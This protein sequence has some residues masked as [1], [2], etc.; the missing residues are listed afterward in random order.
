MSTHMSTHMSARLYDHTSLCACACVSNQTSLHMCVHMCTLSAH[1]PVHVSVH[2]STYPPIFCSFAGPFGPESVLKKMPSESTDEKMAGLGASQLLDFSTAR[3]TADSIGSRLLDRRRG[4]AIEA[5]A[6]NYYRPLLGG[7]VVC[8]A[9]R[10]SVQLIRSLTLSTAAYWVSAGYFIAVGLVLLSTIRIAPM[11]ELVRRPTAWVFMGTTL[12]ANVQVAWMVSADDYCSNETCFLGADGRHRGIFYAV[13][14]LALTIWSGLYVMID[15]LPKRLFLP[16]GRYCLVFDALLTIWNYTTTL[17]IPEAV[18]RGNTWVWSV[19]DSSGNR[20]EVLSSV[21]IGNNA[22]MIHAALVLQFAFSAW[23]RPEKCILIKERLSISS[24]HLKR[25]CDEAVTVSDKLFGCDQG[26]SILNWTCKWH[27]LLVSV[28]IVLT[29]LDWLVDWVLPRN[30]TAHAL[31]SLSMSLSCTLLMFTG[32]LCNRVSV[33]KKLCRRLTCVYYVI[34]CTAAW[35]TLLVW[36]G[37]KEQWLWWMKTII[38]ALLSGSV[39][40]IDALPVEVHEVYS[41]S[42]LLMV[43]LVAGGTYAWLKVHTAE[44]Y[45][46]FDPPEWKNMAGYITFST[47]RKCCDFLFFQAHTHTHVHMHVHVYMHMSAHKDMHICRC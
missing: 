43:I 14:T 17:R 20:H 27:R 47:Y 45:S 8:Y 40:F 18:F 30:K 1:M 41:R 36:R 19:V 12:V 26:A 5:A 15:A 23:R 13:E 25:S 37:P 39:I 24:L 46:E 34:C 4:A 42:G 31:A 28:T 9:M 16:L 38:V 11:R 7:L 21:S 29:V 35:S 33:T 3:E 44:M 32:L 22:T 10:I 2:M 6:L